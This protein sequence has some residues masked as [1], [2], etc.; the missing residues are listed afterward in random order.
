MS[1]FDTKLLKE[2]ADWVVT[3]RY[4]KASD[5]E[6][7]AFENWRQQS[8]AHEAAWARAESVLGTFQQLPSGLGKQVLDSLSDK[9]RRRSLRL[10]SLLLIAAPVGVIT[11]RQQPWQEWTADLSTST[12]ERK[13]VKLADGTQLTLNTASAVNILFS[14]SERRIQLKNGELLITTHL[15]PSPIYRPFVVE[16]SQGLVQA[17]GTRFSIRTLEDKTLVSVFQDTVEIRPRYGVPFKLSAGQQTVFSNKQVQTPIGVDDTAALWEQGMLLA[18]NMRLEDVLAEM[19]RYRSGI[20][21]CHPEVAGMRVSGAIS[22][23]NTDTGLALLAQSLPLRVESITRYW[24]VVR[25]K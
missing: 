22:V 18:K 12:G 17:L 9:G 10:L 6:H 24:V 1:D 16:T 25:A 20:L 21:R 23:S 11:W 14:R 15:D 2:A 7:A 4:D 5:K 8:P 19:S 3:L 13:S